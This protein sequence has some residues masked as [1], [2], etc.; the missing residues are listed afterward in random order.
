MALRPQKD[1]LPDDTAKCY[2][3]LLK[4]GKYLRVVQ[5]FAVHKY[6]SPTER[7]KQAQLEELKR[8]VFKNHP[9]K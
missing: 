4:A 6:P 7:Y 8:V 1:K 2:P 5:V 3:N 9:L